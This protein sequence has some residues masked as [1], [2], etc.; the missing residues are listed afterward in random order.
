VKRFGAQGGNLLTGSGVAKVVS[1]AW[2]GVGGF[3]VWIRHRLAGGC[4]REPFKVGDVDAGTGVFFDRCSICGRV[5][6]FERGS[7]GFDFR[8]AV[9]RFK[10]FQDTRGEPLFDVRAGY[11][12]AIPYG[13]LEVDE[14]VPE[15]PPPGPAKSHHPGE[16]YTSDPTER[17]GESP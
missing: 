3:V 2:P 6:V 10:A 14:T 4:R 11:G 1:E 5:E 9:E 16:L 15:G 7:I 13:V 17:Q 8:L 12:V